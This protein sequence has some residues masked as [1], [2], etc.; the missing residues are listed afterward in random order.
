MARAEGFA[1]IPNWLIRDERVGVY[2]LAVYAALASRSGKGDIFPAQST[3]AKDARCSERQVR[4]A[5]ANLRELGVVSW[6]A[7]KTTRGVRNVY[8]LHPE[9]VLDATMLDSTNE[10]TRQ[11][12]PHP[13]GTPCRTPPAHHAGEEEPSEEEPSEVLIV[14]KPTTT[15]GSQH[16]ERLCILLADLVEANGSKRPTI[17]KKWLDACRLLIDSDGRSPEQ[18]ERAIWWSQ[19]DE[20]WRGNIESMP[21]LR[22]QYDRLRLAAERERKAQSGRNPAAAVRAGQDLVARLEAQTR[23]IGA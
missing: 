7:V 14:G 3:I 18:V 5:L 4:S 19:R 23:S 12:M 16:S 11:D 17:T 2:E 21:T 6:E 15:T 20:F 13:S 9:G 1:P 22:R 10:D 8:F